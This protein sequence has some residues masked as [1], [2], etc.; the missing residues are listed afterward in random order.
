MAGPFSPDVATRLVHEKPG[1]TAEEIVVDALN[2]GIIGSRA[3]NPIA[4]QGGALVKMYQHRRL[5]EVWR[6]ESQR[7]YRYYAKGYST[8][9]NGPG[10]EPPISPEPA[11]QMIGFRPTSEQDRV[12]TAL[13]TAWTGWSRSDVVQW[14]IDQGMSANIGVITEALAALDHLE[15]VGRKKP[16]RAAQV[17]RGSVTENRW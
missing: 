10:V 12:I 11:A 6:D 9:T 7:P 4:S 5:P 16:P 2:R 3:D 1:R 8:A 13:E 17:Q 15:E 14:L